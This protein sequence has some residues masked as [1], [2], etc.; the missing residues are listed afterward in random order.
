MQAV[1]VT[2][3]LV[4]CPI[5]THAFVRCAFRHAGASITNHRTKSACTTNSRSCTQAPTNKAHF[6]V[7]AADELDQTMTSQ[8]AALPCQKAD[9]SGS[10]AECLRPQVWKKPEGGRPPSLGRRDNAHRTRGLGFAS[11]CDFSQEASGQLNS[12]GPHGRGTTCEVQEFDAR[13]TDQEN[14]KWI[15]FLIV[16]HDGSAPL[17]PSPHLPNVSHLIKSTSLPHQKHVNNTNSSKFQHE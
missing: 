12:S 10:V 6:P 14:N 3:P 9:Y 15:G 1:G 2:S 17:R 7:P 13:P 5:C 11:H 16:S 4:V 8:V